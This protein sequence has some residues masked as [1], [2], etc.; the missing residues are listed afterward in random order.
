MKFAP[1]I[2]LDVDGVVCDWWGGII[3]TGKTMGLRDSLPRHP[4]WVSE[5]YGRGSAF[6][7][8]WDVVKADRA[9]WMSLKPI[10]GALASI[11]FTPH[12]YITARPIP[13]QWTI[14]WMN[15]NGF[16]PTCRRVAPSRGESKAQTMMREGAHF[17]VDDKP[18]TVAEVNAIPDAGLYAFLMDQSWNRLYEDGGSRIRSLSEV[19]ER[20][21][22]MTGAPTLTPPPPLPEG[23]LYA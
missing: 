6:N 8:V 10:K 16:G 15:A 4:K 17:L 7:K 14:D 13:A 11:T 12:L 18:D 1:K 22:K 3:A 20:I 19:P 9:W 23:G 5:W 2:A 21:A